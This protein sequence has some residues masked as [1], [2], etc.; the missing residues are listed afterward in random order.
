MASK[1]CNVSKIHVGST[2]L[3]RAR[4]AFD[5]FDPATS[6]NITVAALANNRIRSVHL[7]IFRICMVFDP[8]TAQDNCIDSNSDP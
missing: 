1:L 5:R 2:L 7:D 3:T 6:K 8:S 4:R